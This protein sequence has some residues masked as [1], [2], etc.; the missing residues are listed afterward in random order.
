MVKAIL[1]LRFKQTYRTLFQI[2]VLRLIFLLSLIIFSM[3]TVYIKTADS[4]ISFTI[5]IIFIFL[6]ILL[7]I[8]RKDK[9]FLKSHFPNYK[10]LILSEYFLLSIPLFICVLIHKQWESLLPLFCMLAI[11]QLDIKPRYSKLN[12]KLQRLIPSDSFEWKGGLRKHFFFIVPI[13]LIT[14]VT[15][16]FIGS[17]PTA[18]L[19]LGLIPLDFY[20]KCESYQILMSYELP[21]KQLIYLKVK[22]QIQLFSCLVIPLICLFIAFHAES[23]Y[24]PI[25]EYLILSFLHI[26]IIMTKYAFYEPN[27]KSYAAQ[28]YKTLGVLGALIPVFLPI[29]W[30]LSLR[31]YL[32]AV[33]KLN[34]YLDDYNN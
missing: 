14:V 18:I 1:L 20:D 16:F 28:L 7:Q 29:I 13:W 21:P 23:W 11:P 19:I 17:I 9:L 5:C 30:A 4:K 27:N 34:Y 26:F 25:A 24:I 6:T 10:I 3:L 8:K 31:F 2:G 22:R 33:N 15:C 12:T 32:R